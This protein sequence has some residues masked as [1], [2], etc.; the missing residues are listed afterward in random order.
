MRVLLSMYGSP[1]DVGGLA[2]QLGAEDGNAPVGTGV[3]STGVWR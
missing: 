1:R 3:M 2:V